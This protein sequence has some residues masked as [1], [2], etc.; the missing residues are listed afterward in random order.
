MDIKIRHAD[1]KDFDRIEE[2]FQNAR[3]FMIESKNFIQWRD[4][5]QLFSDIKE[6]IK[7][8]IFYLYEKEGVIEAGF[9]FFIAQDPTYENIYEGSWLNDKP[10]GVIHRLAVVRRHNGI[11]SFCINW[12]FEKFP[13]I[14]IDTHKDN[15]FMQL[16]LNKCGFS[17][18]GLIKKTDGS[19]R[20]A[21]QKED[22]TS[23]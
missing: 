5:Q 8:N 7:N 16:T 2:I 1:I 20:L 11:G 15:I 23:S 17:Y 10:Y 19:L 6:D 21:Y 13:N 12:C 18:C 3:S 22:K 4:S 9:C 14:K